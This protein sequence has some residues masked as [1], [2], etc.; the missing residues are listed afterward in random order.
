MIRALYLDYG[1]FFTFMICL[2]IFT[3]FVLWLSGIAG[4][5]ASPDRKKRRST[6]IYVLCVIVP[7]FPIFWVLM[8]MV[9]EAVK[10]RKHNKALKAARG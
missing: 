4:L 8:D 3:F 7:V 10:I 5:L 9:R 1:F 6:L 2:M